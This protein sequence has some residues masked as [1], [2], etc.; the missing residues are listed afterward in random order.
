MVIASLMERLIPECGITQTPVGVK[1]EH[2]GKDVGLRHV[3]FP[4]ASR[5]NGPAKMWWQRHSALK[6]GATPVGP[7]TGAPAR[8]EH[9]IVKNW[10]THGPRT[11]RSSAMV[12]AVHSTVTGFGALSSL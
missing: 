4:V 3:T 8:K 11:R 2:A 1:K 6:T 5:D 9:V 12:C 10:S 7:I